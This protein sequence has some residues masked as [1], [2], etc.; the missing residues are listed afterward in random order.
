[1]AST[2][3][4]KE[5]GCVLPAG[6]LEPYPALIL[7]DH[8]PV[9]G[10]GSV[11]YLDTA[12]PCVQVSL[13]RRKNQGRRSPSDRSG[14]HD[15]TTIFAATIA[16]SSVPRSRTHGRPGQHDSAP[17][18]AGGFAPQRSWYHASRHD[19]QG[20]RMMFRFRRHA[21]LVGALSVAVLGLSVVSPGHIT[22]AAG[23]PVASLPTDNP[24]NWTPNVLDGQVNA[25]WQF[26][27]KVVIGGTFTQ[28]ADSTVN[29]GT[30]YDRTAL[31]AFDATTGVV[32]ANFDPVLD[33]DVEAIIPATDASTFFI[34]G[35]F[36]T[37]DGA[38]RRKVA[39]AHRQRRLARRH[40][41]CER[42]R[43]SG[44]RSAPG[45]QHAV[46]GWFVHHGGHVIAHVSG[47]ARRR[48]RSRHRQARSGDRRAAQRRCRQ[49]HQDR[50]HAGQQPDVD[51]WQ[52]HVDRGP[53]PA[54]R[55]R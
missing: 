30:V 41:Q 20:H 10:R 53:E 21:L 25:I 7:R 39:E 11:L 47:F 4:S 2:T 46:H 27:T 12:D 49:G 28:I 51:H 37:V 34:G 26:G 33:G 23:P 35:A 40:V 43:R 5:T 29:G 1:M 16:V 55:W 42:R 45:R 14:E 48:H 6:H 50:G 36:N 17:D 22:V 8:R 52:L 18:P 31:A 44:S 19:R 32:D 24:A 54:T 3:G 38:N 13:H 15:E 9:T